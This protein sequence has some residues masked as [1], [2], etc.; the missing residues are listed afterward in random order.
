MCAMQ[1]LQGIHFI[2][3]KHRSQRQGTYKSVDMHQLSEIITQ[4]VSKSYGAEFVATE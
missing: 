1:H 3:A 2:A 4:I